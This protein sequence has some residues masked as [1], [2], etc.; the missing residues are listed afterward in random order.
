MIHILMVVLAVA[1]GGASPAGS[2]AALPELTDRL[3][4]LV[5]RG[6][7][8]EADSLARTEAPRLAAATDATGIPMAEACEAVLRVLSRSSRSLP[9]DADSLA[10]RAVMIRREGLDSLA[11]AHTLYLAAAVRASRTDGRAA[12]RLGEEALHLLLAHAPTDST[13]IIDTYQL[14]GRASLMMEDAQ[15]TETNYRAALAMLERRFGPDD[16]ALADSWMGLAGAAW[17]RNDAAESARL[18]ERALVLLERQAPLDPASMQLVLGGLERTY[19]A[20]GDWPDARRY[21]ERSIAFADSAFGPEDPATA[22]AH[23]RFADVLAYLGDLPEAHRQA[24]IGVTVG[25]R[26]FNGP[27]SLFAS[28]LKI[29]GEVYYDMGALDSAAVRIGEA[30]WV[31][32]AVTG[33][34]DPYANGARS[35]LAVIESERG[36]PQ[37]ALG[38][39]QPLWEVQKR[40]GLRW[41]MSTEE[42]LARIHR[43]LGHHVVA[44]SLFLHIAAVQDSSAGPRAPLTLRARKSHAASR[45]DLGDRTEAYAVARDVQRITRDVLADAVSQL[46]DREAQSF[47]YELTQADDLLL[48]MASDRRG[49]P[50]PLRLEVWDGMMRSRLVVLARRAEARRTLHTDDPE[51][52]RR[53]AQLVAARDTL[54]RLT[55]LALGADRS[56]AGVAQ[57]DEARR[58]R[59]EAERALGE[60]SAEYR[61][62]R[63]SDGSGIGAVLSSLPGDAALVGYR[64]FEFRHTPVASDSGLAPET[65]PRYAA[66]IRAPGRDTIEIVPLGSAK[67]IDDV[68][69]RWIERSAHPIAASDSVAWRR[70]R[71]L[72]TRLRELVWD[73]VRAKA[74][75]A[76]R[77]YVVPDGALAAVNLLALPV[78]RDSWI[79]EAGPSIEELTRESDLVPPHDHGRSG[80]GLLV[81]GDPAFDAAP[82]VQGDDQPLAALDGGLRSVLRDTDSLSLAP[83]PGSAEEV[84]M[85]ADLWRSLDGAHEA[86]LLLGGEADEASFKREAPGKRVV[87]LATHGISLAGRRVGFEPNA[88]AVGGVR[89][90]ERSA[91]DEDRDDLAALALA[92]AGRHDPGNAGEDGWLTSEEVLSMDL[93][94]VDWA[95]LSACETGVG[96]PQARESVQGLVRAFRLAGAR[97]VVAS[98]W[99]V[100]DLATRDWMTRFYGA[101][102]RDGLSTAD[103]VRAACRETIEA[104]R[105]RGESVHPFYWGAFVATGSDH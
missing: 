51:V 8:D 39:I 3:Q 36:H 29:S 47:E 23:S 97:V 78:G 72:G 9:P 41:Q 79:A 38:I 102:W 68:V 4:A 22:V 74:G 11:L 52:I 12:C 37:R 42:G 81:L 43:L 82:R 10:E 85:I 27:N 45:Y 21:G 5:A 80:R 63:P 16:P 18:Y 62:S 94:G 66:L 99:Q 17:S 6:A 75:S 91:L 96:D 59:D 104:R 58:R 87:H 35:R 13:S 56:A 101:H 69:G 64:R 103:A 65:E 55:V 76:T 93:D 25:R 57:L 70:Y 84:R 32:E 92:G 7:V 67:T 100:D 20:I 54:A 46:A 53:N 88:R 1:H 73:P 83:L 90:P 28:A 89:V 2:I 50:P 44:D 60:V 48:T 26:A 19:S 61:D 95:V 24:E 86:R 14:L 33:F 40:R 30:V 15:A 71:D 31:R 105:D 34:G 98:L 77:M 49:L